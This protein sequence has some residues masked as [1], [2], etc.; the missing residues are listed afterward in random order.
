MLEVKKNNPLSHSFTKQFTSTKGIPD[1][2]RSAEMP[3]V[4]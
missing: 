4:R 2:P 1:T 3:P